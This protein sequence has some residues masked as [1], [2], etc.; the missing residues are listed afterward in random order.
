MRRTLIVLVLGL[1]IIASVR[2]FRVPHGSALF[3]HETMPK[4][5]IAELDTL[6]VMVDTR[7]QEAVNT[8]SDEPERSAETV[9]EILKATYLQTRRAAFSVVEMTADYRYII[10]REI[11]P[12]VSRSE[13]YARIN[14]TMGRLCTMAAPPENLTEFLSAIVRD[15]T[16][17][18]VKRDYALQHLTLNWYQRLDSKRQS[19]IRQLVTEATAIREGGIAGTAVLAMDRIRRQSEFYS[20]QDVQ[21]V[22]LEIARDEEAG[23]LSRITAL[24]MARNYGVPEIIEVARNIQGKSRS[25]ALSRIAGAVVR[26][27]TGGSD[28]EGVNEGRPPCLECP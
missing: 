1:G 26:A 19:D 28:S 18:S 23:V 24:E 10:A 16:L 14:A 12:G 17:D 15:D 4:I 8:G 11:P 5:S 6:K 25:S 3:K 2:F 7:E 20:E 22:A 21:R 27:G 13:Y 9:P